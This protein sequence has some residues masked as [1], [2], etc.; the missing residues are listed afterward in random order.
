M[1]HGSEGGGFP[2]WKISA[3]QLAC[4]GYAVLAYSYFGSSDGLTGPRETL[5]GV[6]I[7]DALSALRWLKSSPQVSGKKV[8]LAGTSRGGE[9]ALLMASLAFKDGGEPTPDAVA[10]HAPASKAWGSWN[11]DWVDSRCWFGDV[12]TFHDLLGDSSRFKWNSSCGQDPSQLPE[13][14]RHAWK[15]RGA[16]I[17][18]GT[19]IDVGAIKCPVFISQGMKD[20]VWPSSQ[21]LEIESA[22]K[23]NSVA[24]ETAFYENGD[25]WLSTEDSYDRLCK[26]LSFYRRVLGE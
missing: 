6:E 24:H 9:L 4:D 3:T 2:A 14:Q 20:S 15:W 8:A 18:D 11:H 1:L 26:V 12:P 21:A 7:S 22:L 23:A 13:D 25:H 5:T 19:L 17:K 10:V 16:P